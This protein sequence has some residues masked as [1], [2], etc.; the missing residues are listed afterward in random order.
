MSYIY[1]NVYKQ[2]INLLSINLGCSCIEVGLWSAELVSPNLINTHRF[3][4][5]KHLNSL[6]ANPGITCPQLETLVRVPFQPATRA[7]KY[8]LTEWWWSTMLDAGWLRPLSKDLYSVA[9]LTPTPF[10]ECF[11]KWG[12]TGHIRYGVSSKFLYSVGYR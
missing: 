4:Q 10:A 12:V 6:Y 8:L 1:P 5:G 9:S 3:R 2:A 7:Q 11:R